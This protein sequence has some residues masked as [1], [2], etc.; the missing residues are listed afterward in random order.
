MR[1]T[2]GLSYIFAVALATSSLLACGGDDSD[3]PE[4]QGDVDFD[5]TDV[6]YVIDS[7][8]IPTS[9]TQAS[10][11]GLNLDGDEQGRPDNALGQILATLASQAG[12]GFDLQAEVDTSVD[13]G[14]IIL[15]ANLK[16]KDM[17]M[18]SGVGLWVFL[19]QNPTPAPCV[20]PPTDPPTCGLHLDGS[21]S[22]ELDPSGP[23][24]ALI[25]GQ[26]IGG[27]FTG[28]PGTMTLQLSFAA[29]GEPVILN[30][31]GA[32]AEFTVGA[33]GL[34]NGKLGG[35]ITESELNTN[36]LPA[37]VDLIAE[38]TSEDCM[39]TSPDCCTSGSTGETLLDL[40]DDDDNCVITLAE[41]MES[42]LISSLLAPDVDLLDADG[43]FNPRTDEVKDSL[44]IGIGFSAINGAYTLPSSVT[45]PPQ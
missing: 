26:T 27:K 35:A 29:N 43:N 11:L 37:I 7:L 33:N 18:A 15:L 30:L 25:V 45:T 44:S 28:G 12:D 22:F 17:N 3:G 9:P 4:K 32:R 23:T 20:E 2:K 40:F 34:T 36:V 19:G 21:G 10:Q 13:E 41:L 8:T 5:G 42:S 16:S 1:L 24:D 31:I 6:Q 14:S 38:I 39:G